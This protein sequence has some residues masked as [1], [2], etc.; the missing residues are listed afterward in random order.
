M[1]P[2]TLIYSLVTNTRTRIHSIELP[3]R[4]TARSLQLEL[5]FANVDVWL[6]GFGEIN[7]RILQS[8]SCEETARSSYNRLCGRIKVCTSSLA[9]VRPAGKG[10]TER[11]RKV[12]VLAVYVGYPEDYRVPVEVVHEHTI[13]IP[14]S[15]V[16]EIAGSLYVPRW[17]LR[18]AL[19]D[20]QVRQPYE[21]LVRVEGE[22]DGEEKLWTEVF[23]P[24][25]KY[26]SEPASGVQQKI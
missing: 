13:T 17:F 18:K 6:G 20:R 21:H 23:E 14:A 2:T 24:M 4:A 11:S 5:P 3:I 25:L 26:L 16:K 19:I 12:R 8:F 1:H 7:G 22:W 10:P 9:K 15:T